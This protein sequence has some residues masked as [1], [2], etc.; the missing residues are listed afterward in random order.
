VTDESGRHDEWEVVAE[1]AQRY[2]G[3]LIAL[4]LRDAGIEAHVVDSSSD[5]FPIPASA[6]FEAVRVVVPADRAEA[7]R[8]V[9]EAGVSLPDD[10]E[11]S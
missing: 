11:E 1:I 8:A 9:L 5:P 2:E 10:A 6:D 3:E 4:R 7:A